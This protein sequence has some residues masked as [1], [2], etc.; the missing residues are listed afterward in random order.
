MS[1]PARIPAFAL[2]DAQASKVARQVIKQR[3][4]AAADYWKLVAKH[5]KPSVEAIHQL[6]VWSRR[7]LAALQLFAPLLSA[8][9]AAELQQ[10]LNK[11]R[12]QA[13]KARDCDVLLASLDKKNQAAL[14]DTLPVFKQQRAESAAKLAKSYRKKV[15]AG[16]LREC[17]RD[18]QKQLPATGSN[19]HLP[20]P[21]E[22][23]PW[24]LQQFA[25][26]SAEL[27]RQLQL[28]K[29]SM[30]RAH[31]LR[32][33]G[34][35]VRYAL[36]IGLPS[37]PKHAGKQLYASLESLQE[38]LG[39]LCDEQ[40]QAAQFRELAKGLKPKQRTRLLQ[41]AAEKDRRAAAHFR[42]FTRWWKAA[43]GRKKLLQQFGAILTPP[44]VAAL[45]QRRT[46]VAAQRRK[47]K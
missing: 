18:V 31:A 22:F 26:V 1:K 43:S 46:A 45:K 24:F 17:S 3:V 13:G 16:D 8:E 34:K 21:V 39:E 36:E 29:P 15:R 11:A 41:A 37:L 38:Q 19:G 10:I 42:A 20:P 9:P 27:L 5:E 23:G 4:Q 14:A 2:A 33:D 6:R 35:R 40:A 32:I 7:A 30:R 44:E 12:K 47:R 28:A 25:I